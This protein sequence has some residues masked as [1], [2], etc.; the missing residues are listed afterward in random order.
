MHAVETDFVAQLTVFEAHPPAGR[1]SPGDPLDGPTVVPQAVGEADLKHRPG[2]G[3]VA[4][5]SEREL[6]GGI[7]LSGSGLDKLS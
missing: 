4:S 6:S 1:V 5:Y 7:A 3:P 2:A